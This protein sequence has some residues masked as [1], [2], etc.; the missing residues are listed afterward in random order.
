MSTMSATIKYEL[1]RHLTT[2]KNII[3]RANKM[4]SEK[5]KTM[6]KITI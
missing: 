6:I 4:D 3:L 5:E 1:Y 2:T